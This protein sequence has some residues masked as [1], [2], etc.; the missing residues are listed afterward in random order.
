MRI[1]TTHSDVTWNYVGTIVSMAS[2]FVLL[3]LLMHF[4]ND[5][6]LGLWYVYVAV[7]NLATLSYL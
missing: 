6:E 1:A 2:G 7:S 5:E 3:P 4:L